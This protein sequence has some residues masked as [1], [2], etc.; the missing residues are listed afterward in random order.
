MPD[1][2]H[3]QVGDRSQRPHI[4]QEQLP[5]PCTHLNLLH[6]SKISRLC[7]D[8]DH[9][10]NSGCV[11]AQRLAS[12]EHKKCHSLPSKPIKKQL[13]LYMFRGQCID[14]SA[15]NTQQRCWNTVKTT[16]KWLSSKMHLFCMRSSFVRPVCKLIIHFQNDESD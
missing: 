13:S 16:N 8:R 10:H 7:L 5:G 12:K 14:S 9:N 11:C 2:E 6:W 3:P 4:L 15:F 1:K